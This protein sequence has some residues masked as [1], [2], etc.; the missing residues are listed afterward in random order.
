MLKINE[1]GANEQTI[2][3]TTVYP[4]AQVKPLLINGY[5]VFQFSYDGM[6]PHNLQDDIEYKQM[7]QHYY[8]HATFNSYDFSQFDLPVFEK[9]S[10]V[11]VQYFENNI[12]RDLDNRYKKHIQ[13]AIKM[14]V[15]KMYGMLILVFWIGKKVMFKYMCYLELIQATF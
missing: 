4:M 13:D 6:L 7:I 8:Y 12:I 14:T 5:P 10:I 15:G 3:R 9:S 11:F 1:L 2:R